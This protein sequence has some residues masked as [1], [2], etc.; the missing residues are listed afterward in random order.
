VAILRPRYRVINFRLSSEEYESIYVACLREGYRTMSE[1]ARSA[2]LDRVQLHQTG[3]SHPNGSLSQIS[4]KLDAVVREV[5][6][7]R[8]E[9]QRRSEGTTRQKTAEADAAGVSGI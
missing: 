8:Q 4:S 1:F 5:R 9:A 6:E 2:V 3:Q 7:L